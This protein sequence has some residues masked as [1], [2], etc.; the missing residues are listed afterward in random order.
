MPY[1]YFIQLSYDGSS[2][3]GWQIQPNALTIQALVEDGLGKILGQK[4][5]VTGCGRTDSGV[6]AK[7]FFAHFDVENP[8]SSPE[9]LAYKLDRFL[10]D[11][12]GIEAVIPVSAGS[13]ARFSA[14]WR[15]YQYTLIQKKD[16]FLISKAA[17]IPWKL[18]LDIMNK[19]AQSLLHYSDFEC[20]SKVKTDVSNFRCRIIAANWTQSGHILV[21][22]VRADRF[23]RNM[24]RA[25]VGTLLDLGRGRIN[26]DDLHSIL[27]SHDRR[28]AG[29]SVPARGLVLWDVN[30]KDE[31]FI[32][33][34][35][36]FSYECPDEIESHNNN[37]SKF[38]HGSGKEAYE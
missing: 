17:L 29:T 9:Q 27:E 8:V 33:K 21:F 30:Y 1:R 38:H 20:F 4:T 31:I 28:K 26:M 5:S 12:I 14:E 24:V 7:K 10:P 3:S 36:W 34:A 16:P 15:E 11:T 2:Y 18:D 6:H 25:M 22:H 37:N 35:E 32:Q 23:L 13:H 19:G